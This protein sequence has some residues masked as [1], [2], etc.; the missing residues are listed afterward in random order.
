MLMVVFVLVRDLI[1]GGGLF[2]KGLFVKMV[3]VLLAS[4][5]VCVFINADPFI[6][7]V[8]INFFLKLL[9]VCIM[10]WGR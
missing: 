2:L 6:F 8:F 7:S 10:R 9:C 3:Y 1:C 5:C 4:V